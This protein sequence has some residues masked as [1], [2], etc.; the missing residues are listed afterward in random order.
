MLLVDEHAHVMLSFPKG[1]VIQPYV[2]LS[3][4]QLVEASAG[5]V[6]LNS[7]RRAFAR[8]LLIRHT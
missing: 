6:S 1:L 5:V 8:T 4:S 2:T 7:R 3:G